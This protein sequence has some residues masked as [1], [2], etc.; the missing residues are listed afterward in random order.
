M[1]NMSLYY[2]DVNNLIDDADVMTDLLY[3]IVVLMCCVP[4]N[5][6]I[7]ACPVLWVE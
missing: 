3:P 4:L 7:E 2:A 6:V 5:S 1:Q